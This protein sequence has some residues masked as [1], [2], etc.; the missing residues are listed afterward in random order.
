MKLKENTRYVLRNG[1]VISPLTRLSKLMLANV[2]DSDLGGAFFPMWS[3]DGRFDSFPND[4][5]NDPEYD[6]VGEHND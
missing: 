5:D 3:M 6:I 1:Y 4:V 2:E